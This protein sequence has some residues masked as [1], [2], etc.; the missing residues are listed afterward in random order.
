[1]TELR[2]YAGSAV[3]GVPMAIYWV[4]GVTFCLG[5]LLSLWW[6][7]LR[8]GL[9]YSSL[10]L[11]AE[12]IFLVLCVSVLFRESGEDFHLNLIPLISYFDYGE[13]SYLMEKV[14]LNILNVALFFPVGLLLGCGY[15]NMSW[16]RT[17]GIGVLLSVSIEILQLIFKRGLCE[18][19]DV[20][21]NVAG[22][23]MGYG[24]YRLAS[25]IIKYV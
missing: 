9:C 1:M 16:R 24:V 19:D 22:C 12:W 21:H 11:L 7:G 2:V 3:G 13:N 4:L 14:A 15:K 20:I 8:E 18:T 10:T 5:C 6:K 23:M 17:M 25:K